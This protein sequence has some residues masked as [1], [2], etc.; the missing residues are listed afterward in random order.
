MKLLTLYLYCA[1]I[2]SSHSCTS[3]N[4]QQSPDLC[5]MGVIINAEEY[6]QA[7]QGDVYIDTVII[8]GDCMSIT[9]GA[10]GCSSD[11]WDCKLIGDGS[12][13]ESYPIQTRLRLS[14]ENEEMCDAFFTK[15]I[16]FNIKDLQIESYSEIYLNIDSYS[17][18]GILYEY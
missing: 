6:E 8:S 2:L 13:M 4:D 10:S 3:D 14:L 16:S 7:P 11:T 12:I 1:V 9:F 5:G 18:Q 17:H 15:T